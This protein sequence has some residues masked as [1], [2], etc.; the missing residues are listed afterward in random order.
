MDVI[1]Q[2]YKWDKLAL[3]FQALY[4]DKNVFYL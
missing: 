4:R 1:E 2:N 3:D